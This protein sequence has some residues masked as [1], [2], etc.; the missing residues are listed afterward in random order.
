MA[1]LTRNDIMHK[2]TLLFTHRF[3]GLLLRLE[4][5]LLLRF[6]IRYCNVRFRS[7]S[8][9]A[10]RLLG[11]TPLRLRFRIALIIGC[12]SENVLTVLILHK[13]KMGDL[14]PSPLDEV[15]VEGML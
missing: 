4:R 7:T 3:T 12:E 8:F 6:I 10:C 9:A 13:S 5:L 11:P 2:Y 14:L 15:R 1:Y